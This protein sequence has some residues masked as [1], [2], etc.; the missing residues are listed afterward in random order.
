MPDIHP[1]YEGLWRHQSLERL[2]A[3]SKNYDISVKSCVIIS[4]DHSL[5]Y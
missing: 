3:S 2:L 5:I 4:L 1:V